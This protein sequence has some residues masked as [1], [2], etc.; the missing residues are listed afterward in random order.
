MILRAPRFWEAEQCV[1]VNSSRNCT[2]TKCSGAPGVDLRV[3]SRGQAQTRPRVC[4]GLP[5]TVPM[6][7]V[8][9]GQARCQLRPPVRAHVVQAAPG[10]SQAT[11]GQS[12]AAPG[13]SRATPGPLRSSHSPRTAFP[14][15]PA[16]RSWLTS[17]ASTPSS[18]SMACLGFPSPRADLKKAQEVSTTEE[19]ARLTEY[20]PPPTCQPTPCTEPGRQAGHP[21]PSGS[22]AW[23]SG[24]VQAHSAD[25]RLTQDAARS[26]LLN[27]ARAVRA[28]PG[29]LSLP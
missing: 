21:P 22:K 27:P 6:P 19:K 28:R 29:I 10:Q 17:E 24:L 7:K 3:H 13:Q 23:V 11:P 1:L 5:T 25:S 20:V 8:G 16:C 9:E 18:K 12:Q 4:R 14:G 2:R 15:S 26:P